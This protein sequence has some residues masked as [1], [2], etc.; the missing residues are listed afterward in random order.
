MNYIPNSDADRAGMLQV[1]GATSVDELFHDVP[2]GH[3]Y[4]DLDLPPAASEW[5]SYST[6]ERRARRISISIMWPVSWAP[7]PIGTSSPAWS[8]S[9]SPVPSLHSYT[10][11]QPEISQGTLQAIFEYQSMICALT[12]M[13]IPPMPRTTMEPQPRL[14]RSSWRSISSAAAGARSSSLRPSIPSTAESSAPTC[15]AW[16]CRSW[17]TK[18]PATGPEEL[19]ELVRRGHGLHRDPIA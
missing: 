8:I 19:A 14:R 6:C 4:P 11:Y 17:A 10:P 18:A 12:G 3:R 16:A 9:S 7:A 15:R 13:E 5:R 1:I 2:S